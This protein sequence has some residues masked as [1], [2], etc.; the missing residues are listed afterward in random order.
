MVQEFSGQELKG[1]E[2]GEML[3]RLYYGYKGGIPDGNT[4]SDI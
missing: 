1:K 2:L 3:S 4:Y